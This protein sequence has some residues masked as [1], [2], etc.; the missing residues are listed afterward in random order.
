[1]AAWSKRFDRRW[2]CISATVCGRPA[3]YR[4]A[5]SYAS[6]VGTVAELVLFTIRR[7]GGQRRGA[8]ALAHLRLDLGGDGRVVAEVLLRGLAA[9]TDARLAVVDPRARLL[10]HA[11]GHAQVEQPALARDALRR[12][13]LELGDAERRRDLVL[14]D[15][16]LHAPAD[17]LGA[18][19]DLLDRADVEADR[20]VELQ[21]LATRSG[22]GVSEDNSDLLAKL[23]DE[24]HRRLGLR[25]A[26]GELAQ[27]LAHEPRLQAHVRI[28]H[29]ALDLGARHE[30]RDGVNDDE[31]HGARAHEGVGDLKGLL[32]VVGLR[33]EELVDIDAADPRPRGV[34]RVLGIYE[35]R[36]PAA[37]LDGS[38]GVQRQSRLARGLGAI[39]LDHPAARVPADAERQIERDG[40]ARDRVAALA[41]R[42][43]ELHDRAL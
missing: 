18:V 24:D 9:L 2:R 27:C 43:A 1:M 7:S 3:R 22:F 20:R 25:D 35:R 21:R 14:H 6:P 10:E 37:L 4:T 33:D 30:C 19:L 42:G 40:T 15:L 12:E 29:L 26:A 28:A 13:D 8:G 38:D 39:D 36:R 32:A 5:T 16:D 41:A 17:D 34:E 23:V 31:V 11:G